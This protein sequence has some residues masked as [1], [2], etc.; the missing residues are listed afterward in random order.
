MSEKA[1]AA[2]VKKFLEQVGELDK[3]AD[4]DPNKFSEWEL[5]FLDEQADRADEFGKKIY[6]SEKQAETVDKIYRKVILG[7]DVRENDGAPTKKRNRSA[8]R[9]AE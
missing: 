6:V 5:K 1:S 4:E 7:E 9:T 2:A 3:I 8:N